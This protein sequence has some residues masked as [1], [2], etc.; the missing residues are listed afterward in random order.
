MKIYLARHGQTDWNTE[1]RAQGR[2]DVSLNATGRAQAKELREK[3][4]DLEFDAVYASPLVRAAET[5]EIA[6]GDRYE[7]ICDNRLVERSFG[8]FEGKVLESWAQP[9]E[10]LNIDDVTLEEIPGN[11]ETVKS[12]LAR[13]RDFVDF[14]KQEHPDNARILVVGHGA[15][16]KAF[17]WVLSE[18]GDN[19]AF[20]MKHLENGEVKEYLV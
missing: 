16:S 14:L 20:G 9:V 13:V 3:V 7:I 2:K 12:M 5:A 1:M 19:D 15:M 4:K 11:V 10:G 18:H 6:V 8:D 17:D